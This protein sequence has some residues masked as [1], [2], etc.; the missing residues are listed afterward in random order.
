MKRYYDY[1]DIECKGIRDLINLFNLSI[2]E[3]HCKVI[4]TNDAFNSKYIEHESK[5]DKDKT[6]LI[7]EYDQTISKR[8]NK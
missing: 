8:C 3:D 1:N 6:L 7:K 2:D 4:K 5:G